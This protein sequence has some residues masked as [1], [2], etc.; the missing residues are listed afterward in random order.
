MKKFLGVKLGNASF[1]THNIKIGILTKF[2][3]K[4]FSIGIGVGVIIPTALESNWKD[5]E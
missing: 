5:E 2:N 4:A 3:I 1:Y